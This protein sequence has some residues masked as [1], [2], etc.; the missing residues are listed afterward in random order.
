[1]TTETQDPQH[2]FDLVEGELFHI[3][4]FPYRYT[5]NGKA[6]GGTPPEFARTSRDEMIGGQPTA[7]AAGV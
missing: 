1:M 5:G 2:E 7:V 4:G 3:G 6:T